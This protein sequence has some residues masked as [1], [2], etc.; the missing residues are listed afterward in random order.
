MPTENDLGWQLCIRGRIG[1]NS[2]H[3][4]VGNDDCMIIVS[5]FTTSLCSTTD[6]PTSTSVMNISY[7]VSN[8]SQVC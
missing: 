5:T 2:G 3:G 4:C 7:D 6:A 8:N 1:C